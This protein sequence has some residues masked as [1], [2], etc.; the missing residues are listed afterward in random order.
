MKNVKPKILICGAGRAG[1]SLHYDSYDKSKCDIV[2]FVET[3]ISMHPA[4]LEEIP[5]IEV[6]DSIDTA[7]S[8]ISKLDGVSV[9]TP[10]DTHYKTAKKFL[11]RGVNVLVEKPATSNLDEL[12]TLYKLASE[13]NCF[14]VVVHNHRFLEGIP[15]LLE[16]VARGDIGRPTSIYREMTFTK[17][18]VSMMEKEHW[19]PKLEGGRLMEAMPHSLYLVHAMS[20]NQDLTLE[21]VRIDLDDENKL[22]WPHCEIDELDVNFRGKGLSV[23]IHMAINGKTKGFGKHGPTINCVTGTEG[24]IFWIMGKVFIFKNGRLYPQYSPLKELSNQI[25]RKL[26]LIFSKQSIPSSGHSGVVNSFLECLITGEKPV[27]SPSE[28]LFTQRM[29]EEIG[30]IASSKLI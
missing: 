22:T 17:E 15:Y 10:P 16:S 7:L 23:H 19:A 20:G 12:E 8:K 14:L 3:N 28:A 21:D 11:E 2:G 6:F 4:I 24:T 18:N 1:K 26:K 5:N 25:R 30:A 29:T 9:C 27:T 13:N